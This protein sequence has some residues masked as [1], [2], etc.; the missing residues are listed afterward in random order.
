MKKIYL[1]TL[2][3]C[4]FINAISQE[5]SIKVVP[6]QSSNG[7]IQWNISAD[8]EN[9]NFKNI[10]KIV[11]NLDGLIFSNPIHETENTDNNFLITVTSDKE[12]NADAEVYYKDGSLSK[13]NFKLALKS[14]FSLKIKNTA[15]LIKQGQWEWEAFIAGNH[16]EI[17]KIDHVAYQLNS[18]FKDPYRQI[19]KLG[20]INKPFA[21]NAK[22]WGVFNLKAKVYFKD[23]KTA[24]LEHVL[25]FEKIRVVVFYLASTADV[26]KPIADK[27]A[28]AMEKDNR[29]VTQV[30]PISD[31]T[32]STSSYDL[33]RNEIRYEKLEE[34][35]VD[36]ILILL[37][38]ENISN[39]IEKNIITYKSPEYLSI[40]IIK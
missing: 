5:I 9:I 35:Y 38:N 30:K 2:F 11:Y 25:Q 8:N 33:Q 1:F 4:L 34:A 32:S 7:S 39:P 26:T 16:D 31:K 37:K 28:K 3:A 13:I 21:I 27:I 6:I 36:D 22:G 40:F 12:S 18:G 24:S 15:K 14:S 23:G 10:K 17:M 29:F 19:N 20:N